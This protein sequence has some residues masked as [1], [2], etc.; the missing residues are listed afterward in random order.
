MTSTHEKTLTERHTDYRVQVQHKQC[1]DVLGYTLITLYDRNERPVGA[2][3]KGAGVGVGVGGG[4]GGGMKMN[5]LG[6]D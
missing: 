3:A 1:A 5:D 2:G 6:N 4:G